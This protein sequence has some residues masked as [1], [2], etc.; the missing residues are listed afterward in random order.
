VPASYLTPGLS[1]I[2]YLFRA[3]P[4]LTPPD[5][6]R[7][8]RPAANQGSWA[9]FDEVLQATTPIG[10]SDGKVTLTAVPP[11]VKEGWLKFTP[12]PQLT[13]LRQKE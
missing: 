4:L 2:S 12:N 1:R 6:I 9:W 8:P 7:M 3:G 5:Q 13:Q 11:L 10:G